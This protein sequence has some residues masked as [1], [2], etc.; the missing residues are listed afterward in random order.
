MSIRIR[1]LSTAAIL[2]FF[3][4]LT[5]CHPTNL[6]QAS[7]SDLGPLLHSRPACA[8]PCWQG[9]RPGITDQEQVHSLITTLS[10]DEN[11][12]RPFTVEGKQQCNWQD[13]GSFYVNMV[14]QAGLVEHLLFHPAREVTT[15]FPIEL[16]TGQ[17]I[18][19]ANDQERPNPNLKGRPILADIYHLLGEPDHYA[20]T[21]VRG[22]HGERLFTLTFFY[23][24]GIVIQMGYSQA[25]VDINLHDGCQMHI[26]P[27]I[28]V[29]DVYFTPFTSP[30]D[31]KG[32]ANLYYLD[33]FTWL[34][35]NNIQLTSCQEHYGQPPS[36]PVD[37]SQP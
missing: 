27:T 10:P 34:G 8:A 22:I 3:F 12:C 31:L 25:E 17:N 26:S 7:K 18:T 33:L 9:I 14:I 13:P 20:A 37:F 1:W 16:L 24:E 15:T 19:A 21:L 30:A 2:P 23:Q 5:A 6:S 11:P 32:F 36:T 29:T 4:I 35:R 28:V